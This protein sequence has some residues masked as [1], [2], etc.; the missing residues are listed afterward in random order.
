MAKLLFTVMQIVRM[1]NKP[2]FSGR[3]KELVDLGRF[4]NKKSSSLIVVRGNFHTNK[5]LTIDYELING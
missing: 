1:D 3:T 4:L 5:S 2:L